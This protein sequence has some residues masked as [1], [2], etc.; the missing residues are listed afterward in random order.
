MFKKDK[1]HPYNDTNLCR[2]RGLVWSSSGGQF[3]F[4]PQLDWSP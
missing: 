4:E 2:C 1:G 3:E